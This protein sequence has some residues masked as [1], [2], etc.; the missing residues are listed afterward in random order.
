MFRSALLAFLTAIGSALC[1]LPVFVQPNLELSDWI[2]LTC[3]ALCTGLSIILEHNRWGLIWFA[4]AVG[5]FAGVCL[6]YAIWWPSDPIA[7]PWVPFSVALLTIMAMVV[8][9]VAVPVALKVSVSGRARPKAVW[10]ALCG[11]LLFGPVTLSMTPPLVA[12]RVARNDRIAFERFTSL[13]TALERTAATRTDANR[14]CDGLS[15][16]EHY[17][18]PAFSDVDWRRIAGNFVFA[19][20]YAFGIYCREKGGYTLEIQP[21]RPQGD[22]THRFCTDESGRIGCAVEWNRSRN[23]CLACPK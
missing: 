18:G 6:S 15:L 3:V 9:L 11:C 20:G 12:Y 14:F 22:G 8:S 21:S 5:T 10:F 1:W 23:Q 7:G 17:S 13:K 2:P 19:D 16:K 4:S